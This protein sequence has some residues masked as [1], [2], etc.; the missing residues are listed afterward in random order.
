MNK[1]VRFV[2]SATEP[3]TNAYFQIFQNSF[4]NFCKNLIKISKNFEKWQIFHQNYQKNLNSFINFLNIVKTPPPEARPGVDPPY[5]PSLG[6]PRFPRKIPA[7]DNWWLKI[8]WWFFLGFY[9]DS[10]GIPSNN[11]NI[12]DKFETHYIY[13]SLFQNLSCT[14]SVRHGDLV[15]CWLAAKAWPIGSVETNFWRGLL[16]YKYLSFSS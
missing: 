1:L 12:L 3:P 6:G 15:T 10:C 2:G 8:S 13:C 7:G 16:S 4:P 5:R 9:R 11:N 14:L